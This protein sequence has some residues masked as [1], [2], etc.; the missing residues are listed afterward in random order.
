MTTEPSA[1]AGEGTSL[2]SSQRSLADHASVFAVFLLPT[3]RKRC[4]QSARTDRSEANRKRD[5]HTTLRALNRILN[6]RGRPPRVAIRDIAVLALRD[7]RFDAPAAGRRSAPRGGGVDVERLTARHARHT[8]R[9]WCD[10]VLEP[11]HRLPRQ[12]RDR[13]PCRLHACLPQGLAHLPG[14][15]PPLGL[16]ECECLVDQLGDRSWDILCNARQ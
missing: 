6:G 16:V 3:L 2:R 9:V 12:R 13:R 10:G 8:S 15:R 4:R 11:G 14:A 7:H 5:V 1:I